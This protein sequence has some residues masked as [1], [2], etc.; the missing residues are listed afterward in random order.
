MATASR[1]MMHWHSC[2]QITW[3]VEERLTS[4]MYPIRSR[5]SLAETAHIKHIMHT[6]GE[7]DT[8]VSNSVL[9]WQSQT[10]KQ[11]FTNWSQIFWCFRA[12]LR[13]FEGDPQMA[14][15]TDLQTK[16]TDHNPYVNS[17]INH[18]ESSLSHLD[19]R[20]WMDDT[21]H[22]NRNSQMEEPNVS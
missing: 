22:W 13:E 1:P 18:C 17:W 19:G 2:Y 11:D 14:K 6:N 10:W 15:V 4:R 16:V 20:Q 5:R 8:N 3:P 12:S 21:H 9:L 7:M